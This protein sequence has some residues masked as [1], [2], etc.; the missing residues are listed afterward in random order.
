MFPL[1]RQFSPA[2]SSIQC[3]PILLCCIGFY[4]KSCLFSLSIRTLDLNYLIKN[5]KIQSYLILFFTRVFNWFYILKRLTEEIRVGWDYVQSH[6]VQVIM[7]LDQILILMVAILH[8][9]CFVGG[10]RLCLHLEKSNFY[11]FVNGCYVWL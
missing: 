7:S 3:T 11:Q 4:S 2:G 6:P 1:R 10:T 9:L 8:V 5:S